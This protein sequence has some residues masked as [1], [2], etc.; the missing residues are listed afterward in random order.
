MKPIEIAFLAASLLAGAFVLVMMISLI[1]KAEREK[2]EQDATR[3]K[4]GL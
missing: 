3:E 1:R 2:R 4:P